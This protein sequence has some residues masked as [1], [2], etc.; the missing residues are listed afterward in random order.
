[1]TE[2]SSEALS[3]KVSELQDIVATCASEIPEL[4]VERDAAATAVELAIAADDDAG[5]AAAEAKLASTRAEITRTQDLHDESAA[6][7]RG[8]RDIL[9][10]RARDDQAA[11]RAGHR[12]QAAK[13]ARR[14][15][16]LIDDVDAGLVALEKACAALIE[17]DQE[18]EHA[19]RKAGDAD[20]IRG[21]GPT[22]IRILIKAL[23]MQHA[24]V[25]ADLAAVDRTFRTA[26]VT[27]KSSF[28][29]PIDIDRL[30]RLAGLTTEAA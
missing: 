28:R 13:A 26:D 29:C 16:H 18:I 11:I 15:T 22:R 24:P 3:A 30:E 21:L 27:A 4:I 1:M 25:F 17:C 20:S 14:R 19:M 2:L 9:A 7:L 10:G 6:A 5:Y 8:V 12:A 23:A